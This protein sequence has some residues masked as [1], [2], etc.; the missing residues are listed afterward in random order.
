MKILEQVGS[1]FKLAIYDIRSGV[2][3]LSLRS[4]IFCISAGLLIYF[5]FTVFYPS[6]AD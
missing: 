4:E 2:L 3:N 6:K 5:I 1:G